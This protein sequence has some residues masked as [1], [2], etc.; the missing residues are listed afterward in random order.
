MLTLM[1]IPHST[2]PSLI[3]PL[4]YIASQASPAASASSPGPSDPYWSHQRGSVAAVLEKVHFSLPDM[5]HIAISVR[6]R[7][8]R[9]LIQMGFGMSVCD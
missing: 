7:R 9:C 8:T 1:R 5:N 3:F 4:F 6:S 2:L